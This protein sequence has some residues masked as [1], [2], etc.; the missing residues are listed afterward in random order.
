[1]SDPAEAQDCRRCAFEQTRQAN[2]SVIRC[3]SLPRGTAADRPG[4]VRRPPTVQ[5]KSGRHR[6]EEETVSRG[7]V[8]QFPRQMPQK[9]YIQ[10]WVLSVLTVGLKCTLATSYAALVPPGEFR[11]VCRRDRLTDKQTDGPRTSDR[12]ITLSAIMR[13][14]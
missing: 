9:G 4:Q 2:I 12:Y 3:L 5:A 1:M 10:C 8:G 13:P 7:R 6:C 14:A 11:W